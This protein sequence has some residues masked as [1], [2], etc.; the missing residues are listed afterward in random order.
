LL[1]LHGSLQA[2]ERT[3]AQLFLLVTL[4]AGV[5]Y[6]RLV[7]GDPGY[8]DKARI[9]ELLSDWR[10][11]KRLDEAAAESQ[12]S[13]VCHSP[14]SRA[15]ETSALLQSHH[16]PD[17][18]ER[19]PPANELASSAELAQF[20][21]GECPVCAIPRPLRSRHCRHCGRCVWRFDHH[22]FL[23]SNCV[24]EAN[25]A[26]FWWFLAAQATSIWL[27]L[28]LVQRALQGGGDDPEFLPWLAHVGPL[29]VLA[30][31]Q[32]PAGVFVTLLV[33]IHTAMALVDTTTYE[34]ARRDRLEYM[35]ELPECAFPFAHVLPWVTLGRFCARLGARRAGSLVPLPP[36]IR[37]W[38][39]TCWRNR[40]Y[41]C[42]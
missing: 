12:A 31:V 27:G 13:P 7:L 28:P 4:L 25:H 15:S 24:G 3:H 33:L 21:C 30:V 35:R 29:F 16:P 20:V 6:A 26:L 22:C 9:A 41:S 18:P 39:S 14:R 17:D 40:T 8:V 34:S 23:I 10:A 38:P 42:C 32:W 36:P 19:C 1:I 2:A 37:E 11:C 5:L